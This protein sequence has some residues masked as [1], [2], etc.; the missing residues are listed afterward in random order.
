MRSREEKYKSRIKVLEAL[1]SGISGQTQ[2]HSS[3]T[4][5]KANVAADHVVK[6]DKSKAKDQRLVDEM[7]SLMKDKEDVTRLTKDKEDMA[8]LLKDKEEIIRLMKEKEEMVT[9]IK[10]KEDIGTLKKGKV[11][12][13]DQLAGVHAAKSITYNDDIFRMMK[14]KEESNLTN[15]KLKL[16]LE[17]VK[18]SYEESQRLL[19]ST[20]EDM[21][22]LL[23]DKENS[24]IIIS[25]LRQELAVAG[26]SHK[27]HI[28]ELEG[29]AFQANEE[30]EQRIKEVELMLEDSRMKGR[31]LEESLKSRIET[32]E[33]KEIMVNQFVGLQIQNVQVVSC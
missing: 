20:K 16:E 4:I 25:K 18:S 23:K 29:R 28:Q 3:A 7:S 9:L 22:K 5:E 1:A 19:K 21:R 32:W 11:D 26:K 24:D 17:A 10:E 15:M 8:R 13:R 14:E 33:Q 30:F 6:M 12:D 27:R 31:D 2:I